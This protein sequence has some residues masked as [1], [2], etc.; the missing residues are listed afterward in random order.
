[1]KKIQD[2]L[3]LYLGCEYIMRYVDWHP[4][5]WSV[6]VK[7]T[8][9]RLDDLINDA[10]VEKILLCLRTLSDMTEDEKKALKLTRTAETPEAFRGLLSRHF[11]LFG[12]I[13]AGLAIDKTK[14]KQS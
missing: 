13:E 2:Y 4:G 7:L 6:P 10:S 5:V 8:G 1:M 3:H 14:M 12:L 9:K 11:D